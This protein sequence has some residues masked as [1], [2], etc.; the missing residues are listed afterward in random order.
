LVFLSAFDNARFTSFSSSE[1]SAMGLNCQ[2]ISMRTYITKQ[3]IK[4]ARF[5]YNTIEVHKS[6]ITPIGSLKYRV[7][8]AWG[9]FRTDNVSGDRH[10]L[11]R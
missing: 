5:V 7:H 10:W 8:L 11:H 2:V 4:V 3:T 1:S 6:I 9:G